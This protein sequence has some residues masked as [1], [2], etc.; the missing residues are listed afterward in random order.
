[1][2]RI[3]QSHQIK[4]HLSKGF[5]LSRD[6][7]FLQKLTDV[8]GLYL[9]PPEKALVCGRRRERDTKL[10]VWKGIHFR[11][12]P[13]LRWGDRVRTL[14][15]QGVSILLDQ[16][17]VENL[18]PSQDGRGAEGL[19]VLPTR[20]ADEHG[21]EPDYHWVLSQPAGFSGL[22]ATCKAGSLARGLT[23]FALGLSST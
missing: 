12:Q 14:A 2:N 22:Q 17:P 7:N 5:K 13:A 23:P 19:D 20:R 10:T 11:V 9:N 21:D 18:L 15:L 16:R 8:V 6:P 4:P 3:W 1:V